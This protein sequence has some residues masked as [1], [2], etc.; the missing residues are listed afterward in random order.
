VTQTP[1]DLFATDARAAVLRLL[2][3]VGSPLSAVEIKK[4]LVA[5]GVAKA[6]A[7]KAWPAVQKRLKSEPHVAVDKSRYAWTDRPTVSPATPVSAL[8]AFEFIVKGRL[9]AP[10]KA[11]L[12]EIVRTA[13][14]ETDHGLPDAREVAARQRQA[15]VDGLRTLSE[16]AS[17]VEELIVNEVEPE[18]VI[19]RVRARVKR[20][21]LEPIDRAG[22]QTR[23]DRKMHT[24]IGGVIR[25][26]A[27]V[28]VVRP[29]YVWT[30]DGADVLIGKAVV[31]E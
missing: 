2:Q 14:T 9:P 25:D 7:D 15:T 6:D 28:I 12:V 18:V 27:S 31:E 1:A 13:L 4:E 19:R 29:G 10:R 17:E 3:T 30:D 11:A 23:F 8:D 20:Q 26:G 5:A 22:E 16:L 21:G 24:P